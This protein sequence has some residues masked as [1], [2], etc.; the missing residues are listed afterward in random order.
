MP[1][2]VEGAPSRQLQDHCQGEHQG[3]PDA[4]GARRGT[5]AGGS[6]RAGAP[7]RLSRGH[8]GGGGPWG[9]RSSGGPQTRVCTSALGRAGFQPQPCHRPQLTA[10]DPLPV[11]GLLGGGWAPWG[12]P[13]PCSG[14]QECGGRHREMWGQLSVGRGGLP[15]WEGYPDPMGW[16]PGQGQPGDG[17][18]IKDP[19]ETLVCM[20]SILRG[21][22]GPQT[23]TPGSG[24]NTS[25]WGHGSWAP[26]KTWSVEIPASCLGILGPP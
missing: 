16:F 20:P 9:P 7:R 3:E 24:L 4:S 11:P 17:G 25:S 13:G 22:Q 8:G 5:C 19:A 6:V 12:P 1:D 15:A 18:S 21:G 23:T 10:R 2:G 26:E 14:D